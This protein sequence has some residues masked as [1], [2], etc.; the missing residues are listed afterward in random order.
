MPIITAL[1]ELPNPLVL[2]AAFAFM[3]LVLVGGLLRADAGFFGAMLRF[4]GNAGLAVSFG[5]NLVQLGGAFVG[6]PVMAGVAMAAQ[7]ST[8]VV[9]GGET[10]VPMAPD[11]HYWVEAQINGVAQRFLIDTGATYTTIAPDVAREALIDADEGRTVSLHTANGNAPAQMAHIGEVRVGNI[12]ARDMQAIIA[13]Q[14]GTTNVLGMNF[15]SGLAGWR[16][17]D[18]VMVLSAKE[19]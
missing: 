15:L 3:A 1:L 9:R 4:V 2:G 6:L 5:V 11:G 19:T 10:R 16:V 13:P 18:G 14:I 17:Q 7:A 12:A 8:Q